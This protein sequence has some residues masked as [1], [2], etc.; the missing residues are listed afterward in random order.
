[1]IWNKR[2]KVIM[3]LKRILAAVIAGVT[4]FCC[5]G[6]SDSGLGSG[7]KKMLRVGVKS[8]VIGFGY[9]D[10]VTEEYKGLKIELAKKAC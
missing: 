3:K 6:C 4:T 2:E 10:I 1:M 8:D 5:A 9:K 7:N